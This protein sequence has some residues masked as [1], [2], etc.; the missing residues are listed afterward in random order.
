MTFFPK[1]HVIALRRAYKFDFFPVLP[2]VCPCVQPFSVIKWINEWNWLT[3]FIGQF[4]LSIHF[5]L[6]GRS[7]DRSIEN[8]VLY[9]FECIKRKKSRYLFMHQQSCA[10]YCLIYYVKNVCVPV[11]VKYIRFPHL[12]YRSLITNWRRNWRLNLV[13]FTHSLNYVTFYALR[14]KKERKKN[15]VRIEEVQLFVR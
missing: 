5:T 8:Y 11:S 3:C 2:F 6:Y 10:V 9:T 13:N 1:K 15:I 7:I 14:V 4:L 12:S